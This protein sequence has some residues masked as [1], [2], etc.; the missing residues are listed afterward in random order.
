MPISPGSKLGP[1]EVISLVGSGGMGQVYKAY[2]QRLAREIALK[3]LSSEGQERARFQQ[4][5]EREARAAA[6]VTHPHICTLHDIGE[7]DG[8]SFLVMEYLEGETLATRIARG[9]LP[10]DEAIE[11]ATQ[12]AEALA[13][14]HNRNLVHL[15]LKPANVMLTANGA[16]LLDF[17]LAKL[18]AGVRLHQ[19][20]H[21]PTRTG[22]TELELL[23]GTL[24]YMAPEQLLAHP[25]D[26]R[27]DIFAFGAVAHEMLTGR[28]AFE[29]ETRSEIIAAILDGAPA[30]ARTIRSDTPVLLDRLVKRC[31]ARAPERRWQSAADLAATLRAIIGRSSRRRAKLSTARERVGEPQAIRSLVVLPFEASSPASSQHYLADGMT[32]SLVDS[33]SVIGRLKVISRTSSMRFRGTHKSPSEIAR[34]LGVEGLVRGVV[35]SSGDAVRVRVELLRPGV[36]APLWS[37]TYDRPLTD[38]FRVQSE[39]AETIAAEIHLRLSP[40]ERRRLRS[41]R[42]T[43]PETNE[44]YLRGRYYWNK[45]TPEALQRSFE[46]LSAAVQRDPDHAPSQSALANWYLSAGNNGLVPASE[47]IIR[48]K[49][50]AARALELDGELAEAYACL[51]RIA[52]HELDLQ[53]ARAEFENA[54]RF[55]P[56]LVEPVIWFARVLSFLALHDEAIARIELAK[57]LDPVSPRAYVAASTIHYIAGNYQRAI[58]ESAVALEFEP[59]LPTAFYFSAM[60]H[61]FLGHEQEA[62]DRLQAAAREGHQ[63]AAALPA[64]ALVLV[65]AGRRDEA[66]DLLAEMKE[67]ATRAEVSPYY[68]AEVYLALGDVDKAIG[69]LRRSYELRIPDVIGI[70]VD[71]LFRSLHGDPEFDRILHGLGIRV[72]PGLPVS[73]ASRT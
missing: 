63:H 8:V 38:L 70:G 41:R 48:A 14:A 27:T 72:Q 6:A 62:L 45:E 28:R 58:E 57:Q 51:G 9:Q 73:S 53:R 44:A 12:I 2:D 60:S 15:D 30:S 7:A 66:I 61:F 68:F 20:D 22:R 59:H 40:S 71:P 67:R 16:K 5:L 32:D 64:M 50:A 56:N 49:I 37:A 24:Q 23:A 21:A 33:I 54:F 36:A 13:A 55:N 11:I 4:R 65:Q 42:Q 34:E 19:L 69:Y 25:V 3:I 10:I 1:Y 46:Y 29:G 31:L 43:D 52:M 17:G 39:I 35:S 47:G 26:H 18:R